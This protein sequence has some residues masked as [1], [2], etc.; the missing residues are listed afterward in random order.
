PA[1]CA[2]CL[3]V[4]LGAGPG[5]ALQCV[6]A[7]APLPATRYLVPSLELIQEVKRCYSR[8]GAW[9]DLGE[10]TRPSAGHTWSIRCFG[11]LEIRH[12]DRLVAREA[13][14]R[15]KALTLLRVL[16]L[17]GGKPIGREALCELLWP[18]VD[19][20]VGSNRLHGVLHALRQV[21]EK[22]PPWQHVCLHGDGYCFRNGPSFRVDLFEFERSHAE[23]RRALQ[24]ADPVRAMQ[25]FERACE[26]YQGELFED[27]PYAEW[28]WSDRE[29]CRERYLYM[30]KTVAELS[31]TQG[32]LE[33][34][35]GFYRRALQVGPLREDLH[36]GLMV[37]L[38]RQGR[39]TEALRQ[40]D[41]CAR[42]VRQELDA[43]PLPDTQRLVQALRKALP[44]SNGGSQQGF[45][46]P[47]RV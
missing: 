38:W 32:D 24:S 44:E 22:S 45:S 40:Y 8:D 17:Q 47:L 28:C 13:F 11:P 2:A 31:L 39:R 34:S 10:S 4:D 19:L 36:Q 30:L 5:A 42:L 26:W 9:L 23:G 43:D 35:E 15:Q 37:C 12:E 41:E 6:Y 7:R 25:C 21:L 3:P 1:A 33:K 46:A 18:G 14:V 27:E 20:Q 16:L 29:Q